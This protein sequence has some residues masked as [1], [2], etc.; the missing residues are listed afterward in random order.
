VHLSRLLYKRESLKPNQCYKRPLAPSQK[1]HSSLPSHLKSA[2]LS[3]QEIDQILFKADKTSFQ[4]LKQSTAAAGINS[5]GHNNRHKKT[6]R[7]FKSGTAFKIPHLSPAIEASAR[8]NSVQ[9]KKTP[10]PQA[11]H[12]MPQ[13]QT[14]HMLSISKQL[15][16]RLIRY[17]IF[18]IINP[19]TRSNYLTSRAALRRPDPHLWNKPSRLP[20]L[21][22]L[23]TLSPQ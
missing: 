11:K 6:I 16:I 10:C 22:L 19:S 5:H 14:L 7:N 15:P 12:I 1:Q 21:S 23:Q 9:D 13:A 3:N 4:V 2:P 17:K 20:S 18:W 8:S